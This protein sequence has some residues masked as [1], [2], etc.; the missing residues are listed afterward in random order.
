MTYLSVIIPAYNEE[1][2]LPE[3]IRQISAFLGREKEYRSEI[4][5]VENGSTDRT[6][7]VAQSYLNLFTNHRDNVRGRVIHSKK[8]KGAAIR[9]GM[10]IAQ[11]TWLYMADADLSTPIEAV[12]LMTPPQ[13]TGDIA[14]GSRS[15]PGAE[16]VVKGTPSHRKMTG[17]IF[18][19]LTRLLVPGISDTQC[20]F[21]MF[22]RD[23]ARQIFSQS[24]VDGWA[25][26][27]EILYLARL[28]GYEIKEI[29]VAWEYD[30]D[31]RINVLGDS[32]EMAAD[33]L[34]I[35]IRGKTGGY[36]PQKDPAHA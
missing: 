8:G 35:W 30:E 21:K 26:D 28:Y 23:A 17:W 9:A 1:K 29:L 15:L 19:Q 34:R 27:V 11:G 5:I 2:R 6:S 4:L 3:T 10:M 24:V 25:F 22:R 32:L 14:I 20:G 16:Y 31:S 12:D 7:Q 36:E 13:F 18:N 33:L